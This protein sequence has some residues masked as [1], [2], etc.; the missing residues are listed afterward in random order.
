VTYSPAVE[1]TP[2]AVAVTAVRREGS[3]TIGYGTADDGHPV[4]F[5]GDPRMMAAIA[6]EL[7]AGRS[8]VAVTIEGWQVLAAGGES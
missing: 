6:A 2:I 5:A 7:E 4:L 8:P 3:T 1:Q